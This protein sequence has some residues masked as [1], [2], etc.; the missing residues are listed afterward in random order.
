LFQEGELNPPE[1]SKENILIK[2][3]LNNLEFKRKQTNYAFRINE[4]SDIEAFSTLCKLQKT[5]IGNLEK[6]GV[7]KQKVNNWLE[8]PFYVNY[9]RQ[10]LLFV[11]RNSVIK[12]QDLASL[13]STIDEEGQ[14]RD[15]YSIKVEPIIN[16][17][18]FWSTIEE[19]E[20]LFE[21]NFEL[22]APNLFGAY[23]SANE[24]QK[25]LKS[26]YNQDAVKFGIENKNANLKY[27]TETLE[28]FR[29]YADSGGGHWLLK[30]LKNGRKRVIKSYQNARSLKIDFIDS[31]QDLKDHKE[32]L[33]IFIRE[34]VKGEEKNE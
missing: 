15:H 4:F 10:L 32:K 17:T 2:A 18:K 14:K 25:E 6:H 9:K 21:I 20:G 28:S 3:I 34:I 31:V 7:D 29:D 23:K 27:D 13:L 5:R 8:I 30:I 11:Q 16:P 33:L 26:I 12:I 24:F 19:S 22:N 1:R